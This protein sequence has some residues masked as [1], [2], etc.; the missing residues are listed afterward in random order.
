MLLLLQV[1]NL[2]NIANVVPRPITVAAGIGVVDTIEKK[3]Y[4]N[5]KIQMNVII[6]NNEDSFQSRLLIPYCAV[7]YTKLK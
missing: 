6:D 2:R 1:I 3:L 7:F 5:K 4:N